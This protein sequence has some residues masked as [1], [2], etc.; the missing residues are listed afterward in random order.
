MWPNPLFGM[1]ATTLGVIRD[2][3]WHSGVDAPIIKMA[4]LAR[5]K[6]ATRWNG[7]LAI[8]GCKWT[9][10]WEDSITRRVN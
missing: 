3:A 6:V 2:P 1:P 4:E 7:R 10:K 8:F 5:I 9:L